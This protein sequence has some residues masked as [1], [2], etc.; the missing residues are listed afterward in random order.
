MDELQLLGVS[1]A[2]DD[3]G[4]GQTA[5][6]YFKDFLFDVLKIDGQFIESIDKDLDNQA[7]VKAMISIPNISTC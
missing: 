2:I 4:S 7:L 1:F 3:F 5:L 6:R